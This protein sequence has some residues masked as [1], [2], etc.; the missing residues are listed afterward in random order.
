M[1]ILNVEGASLNYEV[2]PAVSPWISEP[3]TIVFHHGLGASAGIWAKWLPLLT[4][5]FR[6]VRFDMRGH[7]QSTPSSEGTPISLT[8][9]IADL[10]AVADA[11]GAE[12][13]HLVGESLGGTLAMSAALQHPRRIATL[14]VSNGAHVG[15]AIGN[16]RNWA[17]II[18]NEGMRGWSTHM[19]DCRFF[20]GALSKEQWEWYDAQQAGASPEFVLRALEQLVGADLSKQLP[21]LRLPVLL[22]HPDSSPFIPVSLMAQLHASLP[23]SRMQV[24]AHTRHGLPF[25]HASECARVLRA[26]LDERH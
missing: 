9:L 7:G 1:A 14:T 17:Q 18:A 16:V 15:G 11:A 13:F 2:T 10:M 4:D 8:L 19:M 6:V 3:E 5:R 23:D 26:F 20:P 25:S 12:R 24:F 22:L 21:E